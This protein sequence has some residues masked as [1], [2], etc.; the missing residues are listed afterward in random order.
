MSFTQDQT[1][2][3]QLTENL[4]KKAN[5]LFR[6][7]W[8]GCNGENLDDLHVNNCLDGPRHFEIKLMNDLDPARAVYESQYKLPD[9]DCQSYNSYKILIPS[10]LANRANVLVHELVH[11]LQQAF[12]KDI[13]LNSKD[14][15]YLDY[16]SQKCEVEAHFVQLLFIREHELHLVEEV[17]R[18][19]FISMVDEAM[20]DEIKRVDL[21][22][23]ANKND[24]I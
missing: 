24:I 22:L 12:E 13:Y 4:M 6:D 21:I 20:I 3:I 14:N 17:L 5:I 8:K 10:Y 23:F 16:I 9:Y 15:D 11:F 18:P 7:T 1:V 2:F 19:E